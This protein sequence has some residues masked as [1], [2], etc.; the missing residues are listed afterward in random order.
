MKKLFTGR[1][2]TILGFA[3]ALAILTGIISSMFGA[4]WPSRVVRTVITPIRSAISA[5]S[6][7]VERY[8]NFQFSYESLEARNDYLQKRLTQM[9]DDV[10]T[11]DAL[12]REN[13]RLRELCNLRDEHADYVFDDA[14]IVSWDSSSWK[15]A[16]T[17]AKGTGDGLAEGMAVVTEYG[18]VVG[19][20]TEIGPNWA[21]VTTVLDN[22]LEISACVASSGN[23]GVV[24]GAYTYGYPN[25]LRLN[26]LPAETIL[27]NNDQVV[28]TGSS[29]YPKGLILGYIEDAGMDETGVAKYAIVQPAADFDTLEQVFIVTNYQQD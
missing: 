3:L 16:F 19:L 2:K 1:V 26:Y 9:E 13:K 8:Y 6:R 21:T 24:Q 27:R 22:S 17:I 14:Y 29:L 18:Q 23:T 20:I 4:A 25:K 11:A 28:T 7:Q 15:N 5:V 12:E 10:R